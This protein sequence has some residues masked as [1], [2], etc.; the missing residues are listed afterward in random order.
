MDWRAICCRT[1][2]LERNRRRRGYLAHIGGFLAGMALIPF[3]KYRHI[4]LFAVI[5][6]RDWQSPIKFSGSGPTRPLSP[7]CPHCLT[8]LVGVSQRAHQKLC[9]FIEPQKPK[10]GDVIKPDHGDRSGIIPRRLANRRPS[11]S[12]IWA[13]APNSRTSASTSLAADSV[14]ACQ[15][16]SQQRRCQTDRV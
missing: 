5:S 13:S 3:F 4:V 1:A 6:A 2:S 9:A 16:H 7:G 14:T 8:L 10:S 12:T 15:D 11:A